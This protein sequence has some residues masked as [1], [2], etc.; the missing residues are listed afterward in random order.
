MQAITT[1]YLGPTHTK[2]ARIKATSANGESVTVSRNSALRIEDSH[3]E[4]AG[5][6]CVRLDWHGELV[7]G[8]TPD[9]YVYVFMTGDKLEV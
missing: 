5:E 1:K 3:K 6:L 9:G 7:E 4:A 2:G 8:S